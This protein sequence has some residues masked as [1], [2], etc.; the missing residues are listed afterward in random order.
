[1]K[2]VFFTVFKNDAVITKV[3]NKTWLG[4]RIFSCICTCCYP[5]FTCVYRNKTQ[6]FVIKHYCV[7]VTSHDL[8][9]NQP[10]PLPF[11]AQ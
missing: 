9:F 5:D 10:V 1:M 3:C 6:G 7:S 4:T 8:D 2:K 11:C